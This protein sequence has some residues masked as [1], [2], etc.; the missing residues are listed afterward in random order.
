MINFFLA[1]LD[2]ALAQFAFL[3]K[4]FEVIFINKTFVR[5]PTGS[6]VQWLAF[7]L[8]SAGRASINNNSADNRVA[9][10]DQSISFCVNFP[11]IKSINV[12]SSFSSAVVDVVVLHSIGWTIKAKS[13][14]NPWKLTS[15]KETSFV[16]SQ[17]QTVERK[18]HN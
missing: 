15:N 8:F 7:R 18:L 3:A 5:R 4:N 16:V 17:T 11:W 14:E 10:V 1:A 2:S 9:A 13:S 6:E 12:N